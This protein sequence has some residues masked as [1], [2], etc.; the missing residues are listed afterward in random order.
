MIFHSYLNF[1][2]HLADFFGSTLFLLVSAGN[3]K[4]PDFSK[5]CI[6]SIWT[7]IYRKLDNVIT[8]YKNLVM[9]SIS[10]QFSNLKLQ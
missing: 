7:K 4:P 1:E 9:I 6:H 3:A 8:W 5:K 2:N 10:P